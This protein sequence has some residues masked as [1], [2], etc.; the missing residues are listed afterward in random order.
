MSSVTRFTASFD[1]EGECGDWIYE[2]DLAGYIDGEL[3]CEECCDEE[4]S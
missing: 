1:S 4:E 2:G 3:S